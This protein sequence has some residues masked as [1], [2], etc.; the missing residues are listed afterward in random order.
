[1]QIRFW[2]DE[3]SAIFSFGEWVRQ[4]RKSLDLS[5]QVMANLAGYAA[6]TIKQIEQDERR[7]SRLMVERLADALFLPIDESPVF[8]HAVL[9]ERSLDRLPT[10]A[11]PEF[12]PAFPSISSSSVPAAL[13]MG[14][15]TE[16]AEASRLL[17][18][19]TRLLIRIEPPIE[20]AEWQR[21]KG[22]ARALCAPSRFEKAWTEGEGLN[23]KQSVGMANGG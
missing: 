18:L 12:P 14:P 8:L 21:G 20:P 7:P 5:R 13:R 16:T 3:M 9:G 15:R 2:Q 1:M 6:A 11:E 10:P 19:L 22:G 23:L 17:R 4:R